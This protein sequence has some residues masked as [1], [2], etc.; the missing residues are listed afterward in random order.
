MQPD[1]LKRTCSLDEIERPVAPGGQVGGGGHKFLLAHGAHSPYEDH[2]CVSIQ[3][4][5][6]GEDLL[7]LLAPLVPAAPS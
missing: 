7:Q 2:H 4:P 5:A 1:T 6:V 3:G